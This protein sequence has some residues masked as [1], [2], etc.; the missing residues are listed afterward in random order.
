MPL[1]IIRTVPDAAKYTPL[2]TH[3]SA[4]PASF[5]TPVLHFRNESTTLVLAATQTP[6]LPIFGGHKDAAEPEVVVPGIDIWV[7]SENLILYNPSLTVGVELPY[8]S[9]TLHAI[10][11]IPHGKGIYMQLALSP[12]AA[13]TSNNEAFDDDDMLEL[14]ALPCSGDNEDA[15]VDAFFKALSD[16]A[17]LNPDPDASGSDDEGMDG[18]V[19]FE[20]GAG[21][22]LEGF[23]GEGGWITAENVD[24][25]R[26]EDVEG[27][28]EEGEF[29]I[30]GPGA[31]TV[32]ARSEEE[33]GEAELEVVG[34]EEAKWRRTE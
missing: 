18:Q 15:T 7:T 26:F 14:T 2:T 8:T 25:F 11:R 27:E 33:E 20:G 32:R 4:T 31:G 9:V 13:Q 10:Q 6:L 22:T 24:Q 1:T 30:L 17:N 28:G 5:T 16:C 12:S 3:Q 19:M 34:G 29:R 23:P 21:A